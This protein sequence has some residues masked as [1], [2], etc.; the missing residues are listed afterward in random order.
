VKLHDQVGEPLHTLR[1][2]VR[3]CLPSP[4]GPALLPQ[5]L[6]GQFS[7]QN[8]EGP[9][10]HEKMVWT[11]RVPKGKPTDLPVIQPDNVAPGLAARQNGGILKTIILQLLRIAARPW[12]SRTVLPRLFPS[13]T[14]PASGRRSLIRSPSRSRRA[15]YV[16][17]ACHCCEASRAILVT[18]GQNVA[19]S[20]QS[21]LRCVEC[22]PGAALSWNHAQ[23][24]SK[25]ST[26]W[27]LGSLRRN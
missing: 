27:P 22:F 21:A 12:M 4:L 16:F 5:S 11:G 3:S 13:Y 10:A 6:Q 26:R 15:Q 1:G 7:C 8:G 17:R 24:F 14:E 20:R 19:I 2:K 18:S 25:T 9:C 23:R